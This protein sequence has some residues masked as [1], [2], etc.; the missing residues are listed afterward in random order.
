MEG[1]TVDA[2][3]HAAQ[4]LRA[5]VEDMSQMGIAYPAADF[6]T[7]T[8]QGKVIIFI[9][10]IG[11]NGFCES[12]PAAGGNKLILGGEH[13]LTGSDVHIQPRCFLIPEFVLERRFCGVL[14]G[15]VV[16]HFCQVFPHFF[17]CHDFVVLG[18]DAAS[19]FFFDFGKIDM[20][21]ADFW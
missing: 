14:L 10:G 8:V 12:R 1:C 21:V 2:V 6:R 19:L 17:L 9:D 4:F 18:I 16:L 13:G 11:V 20:A 5:V 3:A 7:N 15:Y